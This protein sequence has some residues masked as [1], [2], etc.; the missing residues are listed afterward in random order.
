[1]TIVSRPSMR[2]LACLRQHISGCAF[3]DDNVQDSP[4]RNPGFSNPLERAAAAC[5][6]PHPKPKSINNTHDGDEEMTYKNILVL[7]EYD[8]N[9][10][11]LLTVRISL[12]KRIKRRAQSS[13]LA[14]LS[15]SRTMA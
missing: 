14:F 1:M 4:R 9:T 6:T 8:M 11:Q 10:L 7:G 12:T 5:T 13:K 15:A 3:E 2:K